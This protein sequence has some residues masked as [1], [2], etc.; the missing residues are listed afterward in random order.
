MTLDHLLEKSGEATN[1]ASPEGLS[2]RG[3]LRAGAALGGGLLLGFSLPGLA[4]AASPGA[5]ARRASTPE[6]SSSS[7]PCAT[8]RP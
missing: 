1:S 7:E 4:D 3:L 5:V 8:R 6:R 2:R